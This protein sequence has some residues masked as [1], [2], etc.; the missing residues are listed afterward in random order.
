MKGNNL[1]QERQYRPWEL[2]FDWPNKGDSTHIDNYFHPEYLS[3]TFMIL[4][5]LE[6]PTLGCLNSGGSEIS[7]EWGLSFVN[8]NRNE[9]K[10]YILMLKFI[11]DL[12]QGWM[13][14]RPDHDRETR[15]G[16]RIIR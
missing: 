8:M 9:V 15:R 2:G 1:A 5:L 12:R 14:T 13:K 10:K 11:R 6:D 7:C 16:L 4:D 3:T